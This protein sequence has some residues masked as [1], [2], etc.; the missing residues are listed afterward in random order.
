MVKRPA[1]VVVLGATKGMGRALARRMAER[2]DRLFLLG[3]D[4]DEL[5]RS[6]GDLISR[7]TA[8]HDIGVAICDLE[9]PETFEAAL[10][11][12]E[13]SLGSLDIVFGEVDR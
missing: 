2:G 10:H 1:H 11:E 6:A 8:G 9:R 3:R 7:S 12:A 4:L 5:R 13:A